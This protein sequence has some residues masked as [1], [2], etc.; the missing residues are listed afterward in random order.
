MQ[1]AKKA[2]YSSDARA[3]RLLV[4]L[5]VT[6]SNSLA[7]SLLGSMSNKGLSVLS[8]FGLLVG[9]TSSHTHECTPGLAASPAVCHY[10]HT[11]T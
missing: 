3:D 2:R 6:A 7:I 4:L 10:N 5:P 9:L 1:Y 11:G 8:R